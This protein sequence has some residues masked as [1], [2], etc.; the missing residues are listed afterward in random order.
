MICGHET[1]QAFPIDTHQ[2]AGWPGIPLK[3]LVAS[4]VG[5]LNT[6][7]VKMRIYVVKVPSVL[8]LQITSS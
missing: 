8:W 6:A 3:D 5:R 2:A 4:P 7:L 1:D